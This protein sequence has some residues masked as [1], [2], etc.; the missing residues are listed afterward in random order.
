M[1][2]FRACIQARL[3]CCSR[4]GGMAGA[5][6]LATLVFSISASG[7]VVRTL[8]TFPWDTSRADVIVQ[9]IASDRI[10][11]MVGI[12]TETTNSG[13]LRKTRRIPTEAMQAWVLLDGGAT[14]EQTPRDPPKGA[15]PVGVGN[16]GS[17]TS[18]VTFGFKARSGTNPAAVVVQIED[19]LY[20]FPWQGMPRRRDPARQPRPDR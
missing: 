14:L 20:V 6:V 1:A 12:V 2:K 16:A 17:I 10:V 11:V 15:P 13:V 9:R 3:T 8:G 7:Q 18:F 4:V 5:V 19:H